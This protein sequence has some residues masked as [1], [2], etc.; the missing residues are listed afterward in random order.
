MEIKLIKV[1][2]LSH[3]NAIRLWLVRHDGLTRKQAMSGRNGAMRS[4]MYRDSLSRR[5]SLAIR[6]M[7]FL[8]AFRFCLA[9]CMMEV[10]EY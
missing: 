6:L 2:M 10:M 9:A 1:Q 5:M 7:P 4:A 8:Q 3:A